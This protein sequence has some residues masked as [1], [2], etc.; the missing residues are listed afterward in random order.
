MDMWAPSQSRV[1]GTGDVVQLALEAAEAAA[2]RAAAALMPEEPALDEREESSRDLLGAPGAAGV[3]PLVDPVH[4]PQHR[5]HHEARRHLAEHTA[6]YHLFH[7]PLTGLV[8]A[9]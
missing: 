6:A 8:V 5:E 9:V 2:Q 7:D 3:V 1:E 4:H